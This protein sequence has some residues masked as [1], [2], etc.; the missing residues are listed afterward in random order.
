LPL[1]GAI[2]VEGGFVLE[3]GRLYWA[4]MLDMPGCLRVTN[5]A[6]IYLADVDSAAVP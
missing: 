2:A 4:A 1:P 3:T 6:I 5:L